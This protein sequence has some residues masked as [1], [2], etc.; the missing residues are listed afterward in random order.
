[1]IAVFDSMVLAWWLRDADTSKVDKSLLQRTSWVIETL[2]GQQDRVAVSTVTVAEYL[3]GCAPDKQNE[4]LSA[5]R[6]VVQILPFDEKCSAM[7][8]AN[9]AK[10]KAIRT[11]YGGTRQGRQVFKADA[12]I[13][14]SCKS[15]GAG[16]LYSHDKRLRTMAG[17]VGV[18]ALDLPT[19]PPTLFHPPLPPQGPAA[20]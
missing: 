12:M 1:M 7:L 14:A 9:Y 8:G 18:A 10:F 11:Q 6:K 13:I 15:S 2:I 17:V 4:V 20:A 5:M 3:A 19:A 16:V